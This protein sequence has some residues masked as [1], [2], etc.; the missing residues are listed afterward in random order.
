MFSLL[1]QLDEAVLRFQAMNV[2]HFEHFKPTWISF[3]KGILFCLAPIVVFGL[4]M[5]YERDT[6]EKQIRT[7][8]IAYRDRRFKFI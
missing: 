6:R 4:A 1:L 5:K 3:K 7:G 2:S 8:Q